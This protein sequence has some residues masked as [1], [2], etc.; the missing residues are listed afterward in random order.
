MILIQN[1][2]RW[3]G[4]KLAVSDISLKIPRG[5]IYGV[6]G[7]NG[8][9]KTTSL[10]MLAGVLRPSKGSITVSGYDTVANAQ[11]VKKITGLLPESGGFY[12]RLTA[13]EFLDF[14]GSLY[15]LSQAETQSR[16]DVILKH[17]DFQEYDSLLEELS[18][19]MRQKVVF[20]ASLVNNP[21]A[22]LLDE[23]TATLDP[24]I[25]WEVRGLIRNYAHKKNRT[26]VVSS[27]DHHLIDSVADRVGLMDHGKI[28]LS[29]SPSHIKDQF[30]SDS[31]E[32][33]Y[34]R[35]LGVEK[36]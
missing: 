2:S 26:V 32:T 27:H 10:R 22:L 5:E 21:I 29:A 6:M 18:K 24:L 23:P 4:E 11:E 3:F 17:L 33:C 16:C 9:G 36:A 1:V 35:A 34:F 31:L 15:G 30:H 13:R 25:S 19:G 20:T 7:P 14:I 12:R 28:I 8:A